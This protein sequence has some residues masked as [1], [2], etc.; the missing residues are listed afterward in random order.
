VRNEVSDGS[1]E[2]EGREQSVGYLLAGGLLNATA[3]FRLFSSFEHPD[4]NLDGAFTISDIGIHIKETFFISGDLLIGG[5]AKT[6]FGEFFEMSQNSPNF[7]L[8]FVV[9]AI[10]WFSLFQGLKILI[11]G[12]VE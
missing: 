5:V 4:A 12:K 9:S 6:G 2:P 1:K 11:T 3:F 8:S 10:L 7:V